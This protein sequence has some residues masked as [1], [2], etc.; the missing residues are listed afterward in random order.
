MIY[1]L[2]T[3]VVSAILKGDSSVA[4]KVEEV[5]ERGDEVT[6][7]AISYYET[8]RGLLIPKHQRRYAL[9]RVMVEEYPMLAL[10]RAVL[11]RAARI[12]QTLS[13][14]G[15]P[16]EDA[17]TLIAAI[18]IDHEAILVT[19]NTKHFARVP[20]LNLENWIEKS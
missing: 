6:L 3:N 18:A 19:D 2:D 10:T 5:I 11:D 8:E 4:S 16:L 15:T 20:H 1:T 7:N 9:F 13:G 12:Y 14:L 17:D